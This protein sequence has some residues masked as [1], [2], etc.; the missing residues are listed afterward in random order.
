VRRL[1][2][3]HP[4]SALIADDILEN[5]EVLSALLRDVGVDVVVVVDGREA[6][7][8]VLAGRHDIAF[9]DIRMPVMGGVEA[10]RKIWEEKGRDALKLVAISASVLEHER[11]GYLDAGFDGFIPKPFRAEQVY[12]CLAELLGVE[13]E[14]GELAGVVEEAA[15]DLEGISLP[16]DLFRRLR[17]AAEF[18]NVTELERTLDEV[19]TLGPQ[20]GRLAAHLRG[21]SQDFKMEAILGILEEIGR[22]PAHP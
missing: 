5:R 7:E 11:R 16:E 1:K 15:L 9:L 14:Y 19:E 8:A 18:S 3:G 4:V 2:E 17:Q 21:L 22:Q 20:A 12:A 6:V 13:Y 10:A